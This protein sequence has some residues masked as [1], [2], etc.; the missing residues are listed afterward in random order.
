MVLGLIFA[1]AHAGQISLRCARPVT[2]RGPS[3]A[4]VA[5]VGFTL[6][7]LPAARSG[8]RGSEELSPFR[9][10]VVDIVRRGVFPWVGEAEPFPVYQWGRGAEAKP[11]S[12]KDEMAGLEKFRI[13]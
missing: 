11:Q 6:A 5:G 12:Q 10:R 3:A 8:A 9:R 4:W 13:A 2:A 1:R 7:Q